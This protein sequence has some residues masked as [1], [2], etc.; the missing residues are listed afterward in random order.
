MVFV[1]LSHSVVDTSLLQ[2]LG[3]IG[4]ALLATYSKKDHGWI[5]D[6]GATDHMTF[7]ASL[8]HHHRSPTCST[9]ANANGVPSS[10]TSDVSATLKVI[11]SDNGAEYVN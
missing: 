6:Y 11:H 5:L 10:V 8:F 7:D 1:T 3:N 2:Q 9:V 4:I